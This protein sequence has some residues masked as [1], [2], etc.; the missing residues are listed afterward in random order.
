MAV[1][2]QHHTPIRPTNMSM[3]EAQMK[4]PLLLTA[5]LLFSVSLAQAQ[6]YKCEI[7]GRTV[8]T[9][10]PC[11]PGTVIDPTPASTPAAS[12]ASPDNTTPS[13]IDPATGLPPPLALATDATPLM[14]PVKPAA[15][16]LNYTLRACSL[17][18]PAEILENFS[19]NA[20]QN[21]EDNRFTLQSRELFT[22]QFCNV[23]TKIV[24]TD[25]KGAPEKYL[26]AT[27]KTG[28]KARLCILQPGTSL[29]K[30]DGGIAV[31]LERGL[32]KFE[33]N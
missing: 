27:T 3:R 22:R 31:S 15:D 16:L 21:L 30:C 10:Q 4:H 25:L 19:Q 12:A 13:G 9:D 5:L 20:R 29:D 26:Y 33:E 6:V 11:Q 1:H 7:D 24:Q 14:F 2:F 18:R 23:I 28:D 8:F 17:E 32:L